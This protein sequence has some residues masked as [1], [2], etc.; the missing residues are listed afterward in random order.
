MGC[1]EVNA[2]IGVVTKKAFLLFANF[3]PQLHVQKCFYVLEVCSCK[4]C[5]CYSVHLW[6]S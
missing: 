5:E 2:F 4:R 3:G 1:L 6:S